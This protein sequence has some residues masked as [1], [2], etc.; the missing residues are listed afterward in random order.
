[1]S[2]ANELFARITTSG[3][4]AIDDFIAAFESE[5][6]WLDF[7][8]SRD[9]GSGTKLHQDDRENLAKA[10]SGFANSDGGLVVWGI[11]CKR[12]PK[13][14]ADLP[15]GRHPLQHPH[16]FVSW[17]ENATSSC[18][19]PPASGLENIVVPSQNDPNRGF[20][21]TLIPSSQL[22]PHQCIQPPTNLRYY[23]RTGSSFVPVPHA[24]LAGL[25]G[26]RPQPR[27]LRLYRGEVSLKPKDPFPEVVIDASIHIVNE[28]PGMAQHIFISVIPRAPGGGSQFS[29]QP[30]PNESGI[31]FKQT[32]FGVWCS[33]ITL[34]HFRLPPQVSICALSL[35]GTLVPPFLSDY[36]LRIMVGCEGTAV[37]ITDVRLSPD[38]L[39][40]EYQAAKTM[41]AL[42]TRNAQKH[43]IKTFLGA[44]PETML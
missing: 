12:D 8:R 11:E 34:E 20:V 30:D 39:A 15:S 41:L 28:G 21:A 27:L 44:S 36:T 4:S 9:D 14:G 10:I 40:N 1:M 33:A 3:E 22:A 19:A 35:K 24:V 31:W 42:A 37:D 25:F 2:R 38:E 32:E 23:M 13:T 6:L 5:N 7:K 43:I 29:V 17:L 18:V 26:K 16:R